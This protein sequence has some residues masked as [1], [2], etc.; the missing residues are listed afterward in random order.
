MDKQYCKLFKSI[1][2]STIWQ[3]SKE[4]RLVWITM[5]ALKDRFGEVAGSIPGL[6]SQAG[7]TLEECK[8]A[9]ALLQR[10][11]PYSRTQENE[12][13]RIKE[14]DGGWLILNHDKYRKI[15]GSRAE[16][17]K[18]YRKRTQQSNVA[19][20][21]HNNNLSVND[22]LHNT[23]T[24]HT[25]TDTDTDANT[26]TDTDTDKKLTL[27]EKQKFDATEER[28][29]TPTATFEQPKEMIRPTRPVPDSGCG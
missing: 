2:T 3:E 5:L 16:Y 25:D 15:L 4:T 23:N 20:Q 14:V 22:V 1:L 10:P 13:R 8:Q 26:D 21:L 6:A 9:I 28:N 18:E 11:D 27:S 19:K 7:V 24:T 29:L 17:F 12:G